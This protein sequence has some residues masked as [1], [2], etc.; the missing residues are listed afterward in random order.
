[1]KVIFRRSRDELFLRTVASLVA[2]RLIAV[3]VADREGQRLGI[4]QPYP[5]APDR[6]NR[7]EQGQQG[8]QQHLPAVAL[9]NLRA[10]QRVFHRRRWDFSAPGS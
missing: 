8:K 2:L 1:M 3:G 5:G 4:P 7:Q 6:R 10:R 9:D